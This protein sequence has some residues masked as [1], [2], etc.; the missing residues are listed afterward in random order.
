MIGVA[1]FECP[2][3]THRKQPSASW[4]E[5]RIFDLPAS[6]QVKYSKFSL[7]S[8]RVLFEPAMGE[9]TLGAP[10]NIRKLVGACGLLWHFFAD[11]L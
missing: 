9:T 6:R 11:F 5:A 10:Q 7:S 3:L 4:R 2:A 1:R 8:C